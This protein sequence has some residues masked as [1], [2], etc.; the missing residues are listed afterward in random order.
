MPSCA[1]VGGAGAIRLP[2]RYWR[3]RSTQLRRYFA[4]DL[5]RFDLPLAPA[6][7][8]F[9]QSVF[10]ELL[11]IPYGETC[12]YG[13][14][15]ARLSNLWP[16]HRPGL[17]RQPDPGDHPL[18]SGAVRRRP[19]RIFGGRGQRDEDRAAEARGRLSV[20]ALGSGPVSRA[21]FCQG[22]ENSVLRWVTH[23]IF[24]GKRGRRSTPG[25]AQVRYRQGHDP[26]PGQQDPRHRADGLSRRRQDDAAQPYSQREPRHPL[27]GD[28]QRVRRDLAST[29]TCSSNPTRKSS[30]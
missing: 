30:R 27:C 26:I 4:G 24:T 2:R 11:A 14:L 21:R 22:A 10:R 5:T 23:P 18:P 12:T 19:R 15:A 9:Q 17:R 1:S 28:R 13:D 6:G 8:E 7:N 20:P 3:R 29:T 25:R 16:A